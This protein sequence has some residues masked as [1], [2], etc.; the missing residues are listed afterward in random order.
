MR[1]S[2]YRAT[3]GNK[4]MLNDYHRKLD[5]A[6]NFQLN[7][8][9]SDKQNYA[10][11]YLGSGDHGIFAT[12]EYYPKSGSYDFR[13]KSV[14]TGK[15]DYVKVDFS[16]YNGLKDSVIFK[17]RYGIKLKLSKDNILTFTGTQKPDTNY[18][19]AYDKNGVRIGKLFVYTYKKQTKNVV[20]VS[21]NNAKIDKSITANGLNKIFKPSVTEFKISEDKIEIPDLK[22]FT[23]GG[24]N[25][26]SVYN[27]DQKL[28]LETYDENIKDDNFYLFFVDNVLDKKDSL[29]TS[30]S[31]YMPRGY[32]C[33][34]I[35]EGGSLHTVAHELGHGVGNLE[36]AFTASNFSGKTQNLMDYS[37]GEELYH[38]QWNEIQ[39]PSRVWMK[40]RKEESEGENVEVLDEN[41]KYV[42]WV[43]SPYFSHLIHSEIENWNQNKSNI[44]KA[45]RITELILAA[46]TVDMKYKDIIAKYLNNYC[47]ELTETEFT[48]LREAIKNTIIKCA[49]MENRFGAPKKR[50]SILYLVSGT[51]D[52][53]EDP[54]K[55]EFIDPPYCIKRAEWKVDDMLD[56]MP[57]TDFDETKYEGSWVAN[58]RKVYDNRK[59]LSYKRHFEFSNP[60]Y[61]T[62]YKLIE[63]ENGD[64]FLAK[65]DNVLEYEKLSYYI[66]PKGV[67]SWYATDLNFFPIT[68]DVTKY[69]DAFAFET[70]KFVGSKI[71]P[72]EDA[73]IVFNGEDFD[74][75]SS[76]RV[77]AGVFLALEL[78]QVGKIIKVIK[79]GKYVKYGEEFAFKGAK[80]LLVKEAPDVIIDIS[81]QFLANFLSEILEDD[82]NDVNL[83]LRKAWSKTSIRNALLQK[84]FSINN[85]KNII[86]EEI[87]F[88]TFEFM[89]NLQDD[90]IDSQ[91]VR[92]GAFNCVVEVVLSLV[93]YG[94]HSER[95]NILL[96]NH[97]NLEKIRNY[98]RDSYFVIPSLENFIKTYC[99][100]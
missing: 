38:F 53:Q 77:V 50:Y 40:W 93:K 95:L 59:Q 90:K 14:E 80:E 20:L 68:T 67:R 55:L 96:K 43:Y 19:Y 35:Y 72:F 76:S 11:D 91:D 5:S 82:N 89:T 9:P 34:F 74:G 45:R 36:H 33:G 63:L 21:V 58:D 23:H 29:G 37:Y 79:N 100:P 26:H 66:K 42:V 48:T 4:A 6:A 62:Y 87:L 85:K 69:T 94:L 44:T 12:N 54:K 78:A 28:V 52:V 61:K 60:F 22:N 41:A 2:E 71:L 47:F 51:Q 16:N 49:K 70:F 86:S 8:L 56:Y 98:L 97:E 17:D 27:S 81:M 88:C 3:G 1:I 24:S 31:G 73:Y 25:W 84:S 92:N 32:N 7:F 57:D 46:I 64:L 18:I 39:D 30:V 13:Y 99:K 65:P 83:K 10:F 15:T 75:V